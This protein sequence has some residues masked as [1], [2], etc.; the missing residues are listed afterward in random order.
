[1]HVRMFSTQIDKREI[2]P[3]VEWH[4]E[5]SESL[6]KRV[7]K[8]HVDSFLDLYKSYSKED[9]ALMD[10]QTKESWL[11]E[12]IDEEFNNIEK[13]KI[14]LATISVRNEVV[15]FVTCIVAHFSKNRCKEL[16]REQLKLGGELALAKEQNLSENK[17]K[18]SQYE[19][20]KAELAWFKGR[21]SDLKSDVYVSLLAV[22]PYCYKGEKG[23]LGFGSQLMQA[24]ED[25][26]CN[27]NSITLDTRRINE[28]GRK[29]Y[30]RLGF[31]EVENFTFS[32]H[33]MLKYVGCEK[34]VDRKG[35]FL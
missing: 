33:N 5:L 19:K 23:H 29:F 28:S 12:M 11:S 27:A 18:V 34:T 24:V 31:V 35:A 30:Q 9:L 15:G 3:I 32:S 14:H 2:F 21:I 7:K 1:M 25:R 10:D 13:G 6:K 26:Y 22:K 16:L 8:I 20:V 4:D 17:F